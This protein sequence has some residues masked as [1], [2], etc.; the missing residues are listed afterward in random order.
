MVQQADLIGFGSLPVVLAS[1]FFTGVALALNSATTFADSWVLT[2][3]GFERDIWF[4]QLSAFTP[5]N[6]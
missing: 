6:W 4:R 2:A 1:V 5:G 3:Q